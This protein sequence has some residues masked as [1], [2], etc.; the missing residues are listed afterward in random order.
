MVE[1]DRTSK[2]CT[3]KA[4]DNRVRKVGPVVEKQ[5]NR[6][7]NRWPQELRKARREQDRRLERRWALVWGLRRDFSLALGLRIFRPDVL[8]L[9][10]QIFQVG[11]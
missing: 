11:E 9:A 8:G 2:G 1:R 6:M 10:L 7:G 4:F 3:S 5:P